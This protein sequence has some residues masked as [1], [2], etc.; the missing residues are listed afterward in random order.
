M[1]DSDRVKKSVFDLYN[2]ILE[3][4]PNLQDQLEVS[5]LNATEQNMKVV[6][7]MRTCSMVTD[8]M[9]I[10]VF[11]HTGRY[12]DC[13]IYPIS[14]TQKLPP[15]VKPISADSDGAKPKRNYEPKTILDGNHKFII[16]DLLDTFHSENIDVAR[17]RISKMT[18]IKERI[19]SNEPNLLYE[20]MIRLF[21]YLIKTINQW[22]K[23]KE[24]LETIKRQVL[25][26]LTMENPDL[27][28]ETVKWE[29]ITCESIE[30]G[31]EKHPNARYMRLFPSWFVEC[32]KNPN[33]RSRIECSINLYCNEGIYESIACGII[34]YEMMRL[35]RADHL[36]IRNTNSILG[37][38]N[39]FTDNSGYG[40]GQ[41]IWNKK[42]EDYLEKKREQAEKAK[43]MA[44]VDGDVIMDDAC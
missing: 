32:I 11:G 26:R 35:F 7:N 27:K 33:Q 29:E 4:N 40:R 1:T 34:F 28:P 41:A 17:N 43:Q 39:I 6:V 22:V 16:S 18:H 3:H 31:L 19:G 38:I 21:N 15:K 8:D 42:R 13:S 20:L 9:E 12:F 10:K 23:E 24:K 5:L 14:G 2:D 44:M 37:N 36:L 25:T 30:S